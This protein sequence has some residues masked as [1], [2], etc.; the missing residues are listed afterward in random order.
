MMEAMENMFLSTDDD[1]EVVP[2]PEIV[3]DDFSVRMGDVI[4]AYMLREME[5]EFTKFGGA[6]NA[7]TGFL[8]AIHW[9]EEEVREF[10]SL[11]ERLEVLKGT[12]MAVGPVYM[13]AADRD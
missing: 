8:S 5:N 2:T 10:P 11:L 13:A 4:P 6:A 7:I 12:L 1:S 3:P 9:V